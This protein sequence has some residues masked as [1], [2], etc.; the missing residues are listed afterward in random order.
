MT[1]K[2][3][4]FLVISFRPLYYVFKESLQNINFPYYQKEEQP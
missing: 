2:A 3:E 1:V 4:L